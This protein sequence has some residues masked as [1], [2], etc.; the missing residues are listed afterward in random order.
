MLAA[1]V[2]FSNAPNYVKLRANVPW[3]VLSCV[4]AALLLV[5]MA[6]PHLWAE[7]HGVMFDMAIG[8]AAAFMLLYCTNTLNGV[9]R[10][11]NFL[12]RWFSQ[13]WALR[14]GS[15]SYSLRYHL[16][17]MPTL[18]VYCVLVPAILLIAY[19]FYR[20]FERPFSRSPVLP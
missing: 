7:K 17:E 16:G 13:P 5:L 12:V 6:L 8:V 9:S 18:I 11:E 3:A 19:A 1:V 2:N 10:H 20:I 14:L 15:F 4:S